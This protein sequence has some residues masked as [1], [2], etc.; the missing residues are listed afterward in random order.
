M[1]PSDLIN[2]RVTGTVFDVSED[3]LLWVH[4][5]AAAASFKIVT[6][7]GIASLPEMTRAQMIYIQIFN[8]CHADLF[9][10]L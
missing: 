7:R 2:L 4:L 8:P 10:E 1:A 3:L 9:E 6:V 5:V